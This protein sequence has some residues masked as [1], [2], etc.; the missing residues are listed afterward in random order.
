[1]S[2]QDSLNYLREQVPDFAKKAHPMI[3]KSRKKEP[4]LGIPTLE[5]VKQ[6]L[7]FLLSWIGKDKLPSG[8][9]SFFHIERFDTKGDKHVKIMLKTESGRSLVM[10]SSED[11]KGGINEED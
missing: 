1:M 4:W 3:M 2:L 6:D 8:Y 5:D 11:A 10:I 7:Y 9:L